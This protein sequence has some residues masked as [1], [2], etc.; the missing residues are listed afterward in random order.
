MEDEDYLLQACGHAL[1]K[2]CYPNIRA[3]APSNIGLIILAILS[4]AG[5]DFC[6]SMKKFTA[7][8]ES[9]STQVFSVY[10]YTRSYCSPRF[11]LPFYVVMYFSANSASFLWISPRA[12]HVVYFT[13][14]ESQNVLSVAVFCLLLIH[15]PVVIMDLT[16]SLL[17][18][19]VAHIYAIAWS[20]LQPSPS[21]GSTAK[22]PVKLMLDCVCSAGLSY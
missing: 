15:K 4:R 2:A 21:L 12:D 5:D 9:H 19:D 20:V 22:K 10:R 7:D 8:R 3:V 16:T 6:R 14:D 1:S 18:L 13:L 11:A 17:G